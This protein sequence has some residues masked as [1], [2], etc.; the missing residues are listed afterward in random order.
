MR[1]KSA[2]SIL[3]PAALLLQVSAAS[4]AVCGDAYYNHEIDWPST[5]S[6][7]YSVAGAPPNTCGDLMASR[8]GG[9]YVRGAGWI[10]TDS[11][12]NATKGPWSSNPVDET[13]NVYIDWGTCTSPVRR[14]IW[15]VTPATVSIT[16][17][18]PLNFSGSASDA[19]WGAGFNASWTQ[20]NANYRFN[21]VAGPR[22]WS[23]STGGYTS[24]SQID[25]PCTIAGAP[26]PLI[27]WGTASTQR[28]AYGVHLQGGHYTWQVRIY[29]GGQWVSSSTSFL[30]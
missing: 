24:T 15:D 25:L 5:P 21:S 8:N 9:A 12:G 10:C 13:A 16:S 11:N 23:P 19:A 26:S 4:A 7:Y 20:C 1:M 3:A 17:N 6:L 28:P 14:H 29:D 18:V 2:L 22:W 27:G 30:Y